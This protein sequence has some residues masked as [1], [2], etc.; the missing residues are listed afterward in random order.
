MDFFDMGVLFVISINQGLVGV[1][2][3]LKQLPN[4]KEWVLYRL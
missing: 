2:L 4:V 3:L 1:K